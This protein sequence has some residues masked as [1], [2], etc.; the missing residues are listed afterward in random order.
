MIYS[1][2]HEV[3]AHAPAQY[4]S[5]YCVRPLNPL[6]V[7]FTCERDAPN[8]LSALVKA[9]SKNNSS[10][11]EQQHLPHHPTRVRTKDVCRRCLA[12]SCIFI[13]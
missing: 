7:A 2:R 11:K 3:L 4:I 13:H 8:K 5:T 1:L 12:Q 10:I 6:S 9:A